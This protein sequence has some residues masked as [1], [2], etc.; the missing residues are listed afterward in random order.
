MQRVATLSRQG[1]F[2]PVVDAENRLRFLRDG[3]WVDYDEGRTIAIISPVDG[4]L[5]GH[6]PALSQAD[7]D[8]VFQR[9]QEAQK[10][11]AH[12]SLE[13]RAQCLHRAAQLLEENAEALVSILME[14]IAKARKEAR[15]EVLRSSQYIHF[16]AEEGRRLKGDMLLGD[17]FAPTNR[18]KMALV[19]RVPHSIEAMTR[20]KSIVFNLHEWQ[21]FTGL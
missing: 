6:A 21:G 13:E 5:V 2:E 9:A 4:S 19:Y 8:E 18:N 15:D 12:A 3:Q 11:W 16:T 17:S 20:P 14:E 7:I 1:I 10:G